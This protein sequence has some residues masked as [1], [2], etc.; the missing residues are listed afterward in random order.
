MIESG[1]AGNKVSEDLAKR[2]G[3]PRARKKDP[4]DL[5]ENPLPSGTSKDTLAST[6]GNL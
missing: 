1:A 4:Y 6:G 3:F 2:K 5:D